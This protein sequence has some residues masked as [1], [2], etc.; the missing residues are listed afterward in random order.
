MTTRIRS[1]VAGTVHE[2]SDKAA[3]FW[4]SWGSHE[5]AD[6]PKRKRK[7]STAADDAA[8]TVSADSSDGDNAGTKE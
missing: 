1:I 5:L 3:A 4:T 7:G 6:K 2:V 8:D